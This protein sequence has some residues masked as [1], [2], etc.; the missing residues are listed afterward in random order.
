MAKKF[1]KEL[2]AKVQELFEEITGEKISK[3]QS[4]NFV[5]AFEAYLKQCIIDG[6]DIQWTGFL[7]IKTGVR[8]AYTGRNPKTGEPVEVPQ[9][10][11]IKIAAAKVLK[12]KLNEV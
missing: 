4:D 1:E 7:T 11:T 10:K 9:K 6:E 3:T 5:N 8:K 2:E 12:D